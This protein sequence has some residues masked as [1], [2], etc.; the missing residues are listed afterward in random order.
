MKHIVM[1]K[2][3]QEVPAVVVG[4]MRQAEFTDKPF[5]PQ[6]MNRF[7]HIAVENG[8]NFFDHADIYGL[9]RAE[10]VFGEALAL[11]DSSLRREDLILQ[12][13]CGIRQGF[14]DSSKDYILEAVD[15]ILE[16]F[17][18][19]AKASEITLSREEWYSLYLAAGHI[20]P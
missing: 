8:A 14:F 6:D 1:K 16:R 2:T 3:G 18:E 9:G 10:L 20:L 13:K 4:C 15:G 12:S 17:V 11:P 19:L 5:S 7:I